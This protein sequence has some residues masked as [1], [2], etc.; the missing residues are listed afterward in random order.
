VTKRKCLLA[1]DFIE[2]RYAH[3]GSTL[4]GASRA[5]ARSRSKQIRADSLCRM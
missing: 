5:E 2:S 4:D 3:W 1:V